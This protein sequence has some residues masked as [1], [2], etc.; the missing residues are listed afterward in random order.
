MKTTLII[1]MLVHGTIHLF[2]YSKVLIVLSHRAFQS[3]L[4]RLGWLLSCLL[5]LA[6]AILLYIHQSSWQI[7]CFIAMFTSQLLITS[8]WKEAKYGTI[9]NI[10]LF[11][12][13][14]LVNRLI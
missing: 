2:G 1:L 3:N 14:L 13:I 5:F 9:G 8:T 6:S 11:L 12:M 4:H 7:L 10:L